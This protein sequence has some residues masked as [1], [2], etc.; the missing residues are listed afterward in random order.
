[1][2]LKIPEFPCGNAICCAVHPFFSFSLR[3]AD[4]QSPKPLSALNIMIDGFK[5]KVSDALTI[6]QLFHNPDLDFKSATSLKTGEI[7]NISRADYR[8]LRFEYVNYPHRQTMF[9]SGNLCKYYTGLSNY[10]NLPLYKALE[11]VQALREEFALDMR[12][13]AVLTL[14]WGLNIHLPRQISANRLIQN[15]LVYKGKKPAYHGYENGGM[16]FRIDLSD[17][18]I[19][20]Y[21]KSAQ[22]GDEHGNVMRYEWKATRK[23]QLQRLGIY[24]LGD[25]FNKRCTDKLQ[26]KLLETTDHLLFYD[27]QTKPA[28]IPARSRAVLL[29]YNHP[30]AWERLMHSNPEVYRKKKKSFATQVT[31]ASGVDWNKLLREGIKEASKPLL[32]LEV[33]P[34]LQQA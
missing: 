13:T 10:T 21:N 25:L 26:K 17:F 24:S 31:K 32:N 5:L 27:Y 15:I 33:K 29:E 20:I 19:K 11:G 18:S 4:R 7:S 6:H 34:V 16:M 22:S 3:V 30:H 23:P 2:C 8:G 9:I 28:V 1:M 14:E 12:T